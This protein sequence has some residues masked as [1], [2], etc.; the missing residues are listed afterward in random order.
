MQEIQHS[1]RMMCKVIMSQPLA[2]AHRVV[3]LCRTFDNMG[4]IFV[5]FSVPLPLAIKEVILAECLRVC[6]LRNDKTLRRED[7]A[8]AALNHANACTFL[9][10]F[11][12]ANEGLDLYV[13]FLYVAQGMRA[14]EHPSDVQIIESIFQHTMGVCPR[15][16][17]VLL[18]LASAAAGLA[19]RVRAHA[20]MHASGGPCTR[21]L[22]L[23]NDRAPG[24]PDPLSVSVPGRSNATCGSS[25][26]TWL[27]TQATCSLR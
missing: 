26:Q 6:L 27:I 11:V 7:E 22:Q 13:A 1:V 5:A 10:K 15:S 12:A 21:H 17:H 25:P 20:A 4:D 18:S 3:G 16:H 9:G 2:A 24:G 8:I 19:V 14:Q 23:C